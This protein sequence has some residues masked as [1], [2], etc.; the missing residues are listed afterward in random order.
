MATDPEIKSQLEKNYPDSLALAREY[1]EKT[2]LLMPKINDLKFKFSDQLEQLSLR[3]GTDDQNSLFIKFL[4]QNGKK[5][6]PE[7][8]VLFAFFDYT[9]AM[10]AIIFNMIM[11]EEIRL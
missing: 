5:T 3:F 1:S 10:A 9:E 7:N 8:E 6:L 2:E 11:E 4:E